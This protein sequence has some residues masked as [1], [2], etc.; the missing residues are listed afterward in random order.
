VSGHWHKCRLPT[1]CRPSVA[2]DHQSDLFIQLFVHSLNCECGP[3]RDLTVTDTSPLTARDQLARTAA[4]D[5]WEAIDTFNC[6][7][8]ESCYRR[9][10]F[11]ISVIFSDAD[12]VVYSTL[13]LDKPTGTQGPQQRCIAVIDEGDNKGHRVEAWMVM[14]GESAT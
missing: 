13:W 8:R 12:S 3:D 6:S 7:P 10:P 14:H 4:D 11:T 5:G 2:P 9:A 1:G